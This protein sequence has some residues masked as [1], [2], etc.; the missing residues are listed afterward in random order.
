MKGN[1]TDLMIRVSEGTVGQIT[2]VHGHDFLVVQLNDRRVAAST[3]AATAA[4]TAAS[5]A[6][7]AARCRR[8]RILVEAKNRAFV[9]QA[10]VCVRG[11]KDNEISMINTTLI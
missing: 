9:V 8:H 11:G 1:L 4:A 5:T 10:T 3:A 7:A 6:A 2:R